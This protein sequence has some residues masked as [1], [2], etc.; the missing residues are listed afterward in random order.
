MRS[1]W[2]LGKR[3]A[4]AKDERGFKAVSTYTTAAKMRQVALLYD[5]GGFIAELDVP[6][7]VERTEKAESGHV[8]LH[9]T[10]PMQ[11]FGYVRNVRSV[12]EMSEGVE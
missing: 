5:L 8:D 7:D 4:K 1:Q 2:D 6:D 12:D 9:G 3:P 10:T 11:L